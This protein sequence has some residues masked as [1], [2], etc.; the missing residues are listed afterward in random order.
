VIVADVPEDRVAQLTVPQI[1]L[2]KPEHLSEL[3][4]RHGHISRYFLLLVLREPFIHQNR[5]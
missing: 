5:Q 2:I 4:I 3:M 1:R